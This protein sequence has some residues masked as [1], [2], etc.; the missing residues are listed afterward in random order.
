MCRD[1]R[2]P[3]AVIEQRLERRALEPPP[4]VLFD[5]GPVNG[6]FLDGCG[7]RIAWRWRFRRAHRSG[8]QIV[9][10]VDAQTIGQGSLSTVVPAGAH[11]VQVRM[12]G[13]AVA[14]REFTAH[15]GQLS[16]LSFS[17]TEVAP[18][19]VVARAARSFM[20]RTAARL[21]TVR[22]ASAARSQ[23]RAELRA[24]SAAHAAL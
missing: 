3:A 5:L 12:N 10:R 4:A 23:G 2:V 16:V 13:V 15:A 19:A 24:A 21:L 6:N 18:P 20:D 22:P 8:R 17:P 14:A 9:E 7:R 1:R 11:S